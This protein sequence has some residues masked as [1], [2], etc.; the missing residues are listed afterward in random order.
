MF[1]ELASSRAL[2]MTCPQSEGTA[3][4][5]VARALLEEYGENMMPEQERA[6]VSATGTAYEG[7]HTRFSQRMPF[8]PDVCGLSCVR[9]RQSCD[10]CSSGLRADVQDP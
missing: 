10:R 5:S 6:I 8:H 1:A 9:K 4:P 2:Y 7:A 3:R